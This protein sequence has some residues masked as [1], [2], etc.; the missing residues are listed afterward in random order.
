MLVDALECPLRSPGPYLP[1]EAFQTDRE[2]WQVK[3][4]YYKICQVA[5][6]SKAVILPRGGEFAT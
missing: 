1:L 2:V 3:V 4:L 6:A 5:P